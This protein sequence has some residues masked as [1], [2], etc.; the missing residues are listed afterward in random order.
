MEST[1]TAGLRHT[2][3]AQNVTDTSIVIPTGGK[4][5]NGATVQVRAAAGTIKAWDGALVVAAESLTIDNTGAVDWAA[6]D[7][8]DIVHF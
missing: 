6:T 2:V 5:L 3:T 4:Q 8:I 1:K 7:T